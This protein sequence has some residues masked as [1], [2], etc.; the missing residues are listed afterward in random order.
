MKSKAGKSPTTSRRNFAKSL[1]PAVLALQLAEAPRVEGQP[2]TPKPRQTSPITVGGGGGGRPEVKGL[3]Y[4]SIHF[5]H[6]W[7]KKN[8]PHKPNQY[9]HPTD[10][11]EKL[12]I[13]NQYGAKHEYKVKK[14]GEVVIHCLRESDQQDSPIKV[15]AKPLGIEFEENDYKFENDVHASTARRITTVYIDGVLRFTAVDGN[16]KLDFDDP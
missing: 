9:W 12:W 5:S 8:N 1:V 13:T 2:Q 14:K 10:R 7:Y 16:C 6:T 3:P 11:L 15:T 4:V